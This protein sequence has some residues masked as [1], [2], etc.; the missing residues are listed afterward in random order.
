LSHTTTNSI[1]DAAVTSKLLEQID[2]DIAT[3]YGDT[4]YDKRKVNDA[5]DKPSARLIVPPRKN[6]RIDRIGS[7]GNNGKIRNQAL[8]QMREGGLDEWKRENGYGVVLSSKRQYFES[9]S[10]LE[11][12]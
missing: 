4:G 2:G 1:D 7:W 3:V 11:I 9:N 10:H 5:I 6:A 8:Y 12:G